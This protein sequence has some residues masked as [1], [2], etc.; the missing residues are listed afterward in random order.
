MFGI[1]YDFKK[2]YIGSILTTIGFLFHYVPM[3]ILGM[4][5]MPRRYYDY[6][7]KYETGNFLAGLGG[8]LLCAGILIM[9]VN[10][11]M[12]FRT[13]VVAS[14]NPWGGTTLE[15][16]VPSPPPVHNFVGNPLIKEFPYDFSEI[17]ENAERKEG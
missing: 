7:P 13:R 15:W 3:L 16:T 17:V 10:L 9:F 11:L 14:S 5:G 4:Q 8:Y 6:L 2:A 1:M 12:S